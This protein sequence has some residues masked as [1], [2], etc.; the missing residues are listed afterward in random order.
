MAG[1]NLKA[2]LET[3][4]QLQAIDSQ[5]YGLKGEKEQKP[6]ELKVL[7]VSFEE[8]K[9][10]LAALEASSLDVQ[11]QK[12]DKELELGS[13]E[14]ATKKLQ[15]QLYSLKT[16]KEYQTML[17]QISD[18]KADASVIEDKILTLFDQIDRIKNEIEQEKTKLAAEEKIFNEQKKLVDD[19]I[20]E[21]EQTLSQLDAQRQRLIPTINQDILA[22]YERI[23][24][25]RAG[26]AIVS[27]KDNSCMGCN[28][29]TPHQVINL[30]KMYEGIVTCEVCNRILY[31]PE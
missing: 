3:L 17:Q 2:Q 19:R 14:E 7:Q 15:S 12:K 6:Q 5:I 31:I 27:I 28:M 26:L 13:R 24:L 10:K 4:V 22:Q 8:K 9:Q 1:T 21:I 16:N 25:N 18:S 30:V 20:K 23:L 29:L 11:K